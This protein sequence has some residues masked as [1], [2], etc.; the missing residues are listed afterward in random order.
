[1]QE[2]AVVLPAFDS[3]GSIRCR[4][5]EPFEAKTVESVT[6]ATQSRK[7]SGVFGHSHRASMAKR[8][9]GGSDQ[10]ASA[11]ARRSSNQKAADLQASH[12]HIAK[13]IAWLLGTGTRF[14]KT[15]MIVL[16]LDYLDH[17]GETKYLSHCL[18]KRQTSFKK[19]CADTKDTQRR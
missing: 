8:K 11:K 1:M 15:T 4:F 17:I 12:P 19:H 13:V 3:V 14:F 18:C 5:T 10:N 2:I 16:P 9:S 7:G 6:K